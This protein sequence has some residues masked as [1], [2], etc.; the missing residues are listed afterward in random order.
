MINKLKT[1]AKGGHITSPRDAG[2]VPRTTTAHT[3]P[4]FCP[5]PETTS[6]N[7][8]PSCKRNLNPKIPMKPHT[9]NLA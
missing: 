7:I 1:K 3:H 9:S 2:P 8:D 4:Q 6:L 5:I